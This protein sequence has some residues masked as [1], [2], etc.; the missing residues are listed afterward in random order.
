MNN[1]FSMSRIGVV[2]G[3]FVLAGAFSPNDAIA[4]TQ[5]SGQATGVRATVLGIPIVL[6]DTGPLPA[7]GGA[8]EASLLDASIPGV[9]EV[10]V[11]HAA[12]VGQGQTSRAEASVAQV[13]ITVSGTT[14][15]AEFLMS[16]ATAICTATGPAVQGGSDIARLLIN[17]QE[18]VVTG[19]PNQTIDLGLVKVII[20]EQSSNISGNRAEI[21]VT[22]LHVIAPGVADIEVAKAHADVVC[23]GPRACPNERD[24]VTGGGWILPRDGMR[25]KATFAVAGGIKNGY[26]GHLNYIDHGTGMKV[27]GT[28]V[29]VYTVT[30]EKSRHIEGTCEINGV[31]G[32]YIVDVADNDEPGRGIDTFSIRL[33]NGYTA[34][35][36]LGGGNIQLHTCK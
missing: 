20:N 22:A 36:T 26:W 17:G 7:E 30:G 24:F 32:T 25:D 2:F 16:E 3:L 31:G 21:T 13:Q 15:G 6:S 23:Q 9:L 1:N 19:A 28:G 10:G 29:T 12:T 33:S 18:V 4:Q 5:F 34:M 14:L 8:L 35:E 27:K 11:L